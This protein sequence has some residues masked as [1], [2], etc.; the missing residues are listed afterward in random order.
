M[1]VSR[2]DPN[3]NAPP[4]PFFIINSI[5]CIA[6]TIGILWFAVGVE[7]QNSRA[8]IIFEEM[9]KHSLSIVAGLIGLI[10]LILAGSFWGAKSSKK[11]PPE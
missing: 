4:R 5:L 9:L 11:S 2:N 3:L 1:L 6:G 8:Q 10:I 7:R